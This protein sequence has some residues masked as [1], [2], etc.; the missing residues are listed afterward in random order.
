MFFREGVRVDFSK[1]SG[2]VIF[3]VGVASCGLKSVVMLYQ[4]TNSVLKTVVETS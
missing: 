1:S 4:K 3:G 2:G